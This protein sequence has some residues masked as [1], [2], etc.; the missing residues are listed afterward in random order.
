MHGLASKTARERSPRC[1]PISIERP[2]MRK[3]NRLRQGLI[4]VAAISTSRKKP[5]RGSRS[6]LCKSYWM[7][8]LTPRRLSLNLSLI[9]PQGWQVR[10]ALLALLALALDV[11]GLLYLT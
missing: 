10:I 8:A 4:A 5:A 2:I 3:T 7:A 1:E 9:R 11:S 6:R